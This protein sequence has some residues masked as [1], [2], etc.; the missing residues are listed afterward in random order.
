MHVIQLALAQTPYAKA[1]REAIR[2]EQAFR[3]WK[4]LPVERPD[5]DKTGVIVVDAETLDRLMLPVPNPERVVLITRKDPEH[6][7]RA[8]NAGIVSVVFDNEPVS[9]AMLAILAARF[10]IPKKPEPLAKSPRS[11]RKA[12]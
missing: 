11:Q 1:L 7:G 5:P 3:G 12:S 9:T 2:R 6:L 8:W 4:V 10:R